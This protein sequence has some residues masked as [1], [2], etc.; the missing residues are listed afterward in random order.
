M[1][2]FVIS[3]KIT[4]VMLNVKELGIHA[5]MLYFIR[6][7]VVNSAF[8]FAC[9]MNFEVSDCLSANGD[10]FFYVLCVCKGIGSVP[11]FI[12]NSL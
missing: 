2:P 5:R 3:E 11:T 4:V 6:S 10:F 9:S 1:K 7:I 12:V 8:T